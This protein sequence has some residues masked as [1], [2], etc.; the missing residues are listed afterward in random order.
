VE[1]RVRDGTP[2]IES[3]NKELAKADGELIPVKLTPHSLR[4]TSA[5]ILLAVGEPAPDV[6]QQMGHTTAELTLAIYG[7]AMNR[8]DGE[9]DRLRALVHGDNWAA[10]SQ[11]KGNN[12]G[13]A[14]AKIGRPMN[15]GR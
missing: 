9:P 3:A 6:M 12:G 10:K 14:D 1:L 15:A 7:R 13:E 2:A 11:R 8:R 4:R 5:S